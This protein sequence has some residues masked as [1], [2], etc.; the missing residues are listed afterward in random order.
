MSLTDRRLKALDELT[1]L[2][3]NTTDF[4]GTIAS[5]G[6]AILHAYLCTKGTTPL[7]EPNDID[8]WVGFKNTGGTDNAILDLVVEWVSRMKT[9][10][11]YAFYLRRRKPTQAIHEDQFRDY[12]DHHT[13]MTVDCVTSIG[14]FQFIHYNVNGHIKH[15]G[16]DIPPG[17][18]L[19]SF[20]LDICEISY[21]D[22][23]FHVHGDE[24]AMF[25]RKPASIYISNNF[26]N[27]N[28]VPQL[29][30]N[31]PWEKRALKYIN[32]GYEIHHNDQKPGMKNFHVP[33]INFFQYSHS[34]PELW[35]EF[36]Y[37]NEM[38]ITL[39]AAWRECRYNPEYKMCR[40]IQIKNLEKSVGKGVWG[41]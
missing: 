4:E 34:I 9:A 10:V 2:A 1:E 12:V 29:G 22:R 14:R 39:Q 41:S 15:P 28:V 31:N 20:D 17:Y 33:P 27:G 8:V 13:C 19:W 16:H 26:P 25:K 7:W 37:A 30:D 32:R 40:T 23:R 35:G 36:V 24:D 3:K 18:P 5:A 6:S 38:L 21:K 11:P